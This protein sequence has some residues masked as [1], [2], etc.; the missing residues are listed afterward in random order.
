M[1]EEV[2]DQNIQKQIDDFFVENLASHGTVKTFEKGEIIRQDDL[3]YMYVLLEGELNQVMHSKE[4]DEIV[5]FRIMAG[6]IFGEMAFFEKSNTF[7]VNKALTKGKFAIVNRE[8]VES[9]LKENPQIY[10]YFLISIIRKFRAVMFEI[11]NFHFN[12]S[13][14][15][16][17]D[18]IIRLY[19]TETEEPKNHISITFTHEE[20]ANR[21]GLNR[22]TVTN[23]MK[24]FKE[25]GLIDIQNRRI[26]IKNIEG[27]KEI[28]NI[29]I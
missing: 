19:Y 25:E 26:I 8:F 4:G 2:F 20:I 12:D 5:F 6:N 9:K 18:F 28:T 22:I 29:P 11:S 27:L 3:N 24:K 23:G 14:G 21:L 16:L 15:R 17:A 13:I 10:N 1:Y 7:A